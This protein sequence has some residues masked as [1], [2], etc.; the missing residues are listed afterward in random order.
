MEVR[1]DVT[2]EKHVVDDVACAGGGGVFRAPARLVLRES[3]ATRTQ[4]GGAARD[5]LG[6]PD[7]VHGS[8]VDGTR[9]RDREVLDPAVRVDKGGA[10]TPHRVT[11]DNQNVVPDVNAEVRAQVEDVELDELLA[12]EKAGS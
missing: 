10:A 11:V 2:L 12:E 3:R 9:A 6:E 4:E 1:H 7:G 5:R 8:A